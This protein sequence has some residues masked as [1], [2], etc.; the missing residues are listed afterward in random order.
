MTRSP[1]ETCWHLHD[2]E[3]SYGLAQRA[4]LVRV[5][6]AHLVAEL[7]A[8]VDGLAIALVSRARGVEL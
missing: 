6:I 4:L 2:R 8:Q 7:Y 3:R 5:V 1:L